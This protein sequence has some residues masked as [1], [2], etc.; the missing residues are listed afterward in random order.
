MTERSRRGLFRSVVIFLIGQYLIILLA[1][2][3]YVW[4][5]LPNKYVCLPTIQ[6][7]YT[8]LIPPPPPPP[9]DTL[10][11]YAAHSISTTMQ[12]MQT[13]LGTLYLH[14]A[15]SLY[16]HTEQAT[17]YSCHPLAQGYCAAEEHFSSQFLAHKS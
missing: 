5:L 13:T 14:V 1:S 15:Y 9:Q 3:T 8:R 2:E 16:L 12:Y 10:R 11:L 6:S 4:Q 17:L 7:T